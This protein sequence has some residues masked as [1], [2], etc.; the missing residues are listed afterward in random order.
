LTRVLFV[1]GLESGPGGNKPRAL[2]EAGFEVTALQ[3]PCGRDAILRDPATLGTLG[4]AALGLGLAARRGP[5]A[6]AGGLAALTALGPWAMILAT[7]RAFEKSVAVQ[8][9]ALARAPVPGFDVLVGSSFGGAVALELLLQGAWRGPTVLLCP[10][11]ERVAARAWR[12]APPGL[13]ALPD[14]VARRVL[15]VHGRAD[16]VVP[17]DHSRRLVGARQDQ[18]LEVDDDHRLVQTAT[19]EGLRAWLLRAQMQGVA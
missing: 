19:S 12:P 5:L 3:M 16:E 2:R 7:R 9:D 17:I 4:A 1:H 18:L 13:S 11:H 15:V 14:E 10:A 8:R 6:L